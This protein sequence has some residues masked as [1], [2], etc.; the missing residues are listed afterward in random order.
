MLLQNMIYRCCH[1]FDSVTEDMLFSSHTVKSLSHG[2]D[3]FAKTAMLIQHFFLGDQR[4]FA[5]TE[6][7]SK[8]SA[9]SAD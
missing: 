4:F 1:V 9:A 3:K 2:F 7:S 6:K 8:I 5:R